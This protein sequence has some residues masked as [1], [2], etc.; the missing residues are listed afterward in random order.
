MSES[1]PKPAAPTVGRVIYVRSNLWAGVLAAVVTAVISTATPERP[2]ATEVHANVLVDGYTGADVLA[3][4]R[5]RPEGNTVVLEYGVQNPGDTGPAPDG[6]DWFMGEWMPFQVG[7]VPASLAVQGQLTALAE[8]VAALASPSP[9]PDVAAAACI[10]IG[11]AVLHLAEKLEKNNPGN[12]R[13]GL[14]AAVSA[15]LNG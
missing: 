5:S 15:I 6:R 1:K 9:A 8:K 2:D 4:F 10:K 3:Y 14:V 12:R 11:T 13:A 7:Q